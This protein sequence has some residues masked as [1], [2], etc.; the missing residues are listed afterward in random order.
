MN[1]RGANTI[2][3]VIVT[4]MVTS[5]LCYIFFT[6]GQY[7][8]GLEGELTENDSSIADLYP[9]TISSSESSS[10]SKKLSS[11]KKIIDDEFLYDYDSEKLADGLAVGMLAAL[12]D[13]YASYYNKEQFK[14]FYTQ[15]EGEYVGIGVYVAYDRVMGMP[16]VLAPLEDSPAHEAG[17]LPG[18]YIIYVDDLKSS[19]TDYNTIIDAIKGISGTTVKIGIARL[20]EEK[21]EELIELEVVRKKIELNPVTSQTYDNNIGYI[22][23]TSFDETTYENFKAEYEKLLSQQVKGLIIDLRDNPG[24]VLSVC[25]QI[26]DLIVPKGKIVYTVDK[27]GHEEALYSDERHIE[28]PLVVLVNGNSASASEVFTGAVKDYGVG[29]VIGKKTYGK[30]VVQT[31]KS[32]RDGTYIKLTTSEYFSPNGNKIDKE[33]VTPDIEV[34]LPETVKSTY[35]LKFEDDTQLQRAI[36]ELKKKV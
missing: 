4:A 11:L 29:T 27:K 33:G 14:A 16:I 24:G 36:E 5:L 26:T 21:E 28:I 25:A 7:K 18:D 20:N 12:D 34:D 8:K 10:V 22:R 1:N 32:L 19:E 23:L 31:L 15:T 13:P 30:G 17:I 6:L 2:I 3:V 35:N 9:S